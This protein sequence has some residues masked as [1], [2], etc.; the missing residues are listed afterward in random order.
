MTKTYK[1]FQ[2][3]FAQNYQ[4]IKKMK[5]RSSS[6][7]CMK[8]EE[9]NCINRKFN[10]SEQLSLRKASFSALLLLISHQSYV[11][12]FTSCLGRIEGSTIYLYKYS[13][14]N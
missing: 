8:N 12:L 11:E 10:I 14:G 6:K 4:E 7:M 13:E 1:I 3:L 5:I 2:S 9:F